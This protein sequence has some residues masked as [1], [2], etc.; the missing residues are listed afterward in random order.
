MTGRLVEETADKLVL[1]PDPLKPNTKVE[2][3]KTDVK[4]RTFS[5]L[6]PMPEGLVS[7]LSQEDI[8][9]L[10]AFLEAAGRKDHPAFAK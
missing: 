7:G 6:S 10:V 8:L 9:D 2:V 1:V 4:S 3:K 5:K